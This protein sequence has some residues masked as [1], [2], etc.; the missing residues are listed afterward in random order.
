MLQEY[1]KRH[2]RIWPEMLGLMREAGIRNYSLWNAGDEI[3]EY[4]ETDDGARTEETIAKSG[5]KKKW[6]EYMSDIIRKTE[7]SRTVPAME[8]VFEFL[9]GTEDEH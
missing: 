9:G 7:G 1:K 5:V 8:M 2:D 6:D 3:V 4:F